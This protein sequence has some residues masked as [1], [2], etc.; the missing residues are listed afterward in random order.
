M[1]Q[2][3]KHCLQVSKT[4][5]SLY[6]EDSKEAIVGLYHDYLEDSIMDEQELSALVLKRPDGQEVMEAVRVISRSPQETYFSYIERVKHHPLAK[7]VK[8]VDLIVNMFLREEPPVDS[9][10]KRYTK[11]LKTLIE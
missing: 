3:L 2:T 6:G 10:R 11:A 4:C 1:E 5:A 9:L 7:K 8:I